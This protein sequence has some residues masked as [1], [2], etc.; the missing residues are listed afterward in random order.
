MADF[1][2]KTNNI[3]ADEKEIITYFENLLT[4]KLFDKIYPLVLDKQSGGFLCNLAY[5]WSFVDP[6]DKMIV[7]QARHT[8]TPAKA[9][10]FFPDDPKFLEAFQHGYKF[11]KEVMWDKEFG[12]FYTMRNPQGGISDYRGYFEEKRTYG[13]AFGIYA[14]AAVYELTK[15]EEVLDFAI[16]AFNWIEAHA[17]DSESGGYFQFLTREGKPFGKF[18]IENTKAS[19]AVEAHYKDQNSSIHLL[20]AY[21]EL[22]K[23]FPNE[24]VKSR[25]LELLL[26]IRDKITTE[27]GYMNLFFD[28]QWNPLSFRNSTEE[29]RIKNYGLD[30]VSF[31]HD[32]ETAFLML[33]ASHALGLENDGRTL[34]VARKMVDHA[35]DNGF[36]K[37]LGGFYD[38]GYYFKDSKTCTIINDKKN[39]WSQ[40]EG[41]NSLLLMSKIFPQE[42]KYYSHF[43]KLLKYV[44]NY[45]IDHEYGGWYEGGLDKE[46]EKK[47]GPKGHIWKACYHEG[48]SLMNCIKLLNGKNYHL[49]ATNE[50]FRKIKDETD[51][52]IKHWKQVQ[53]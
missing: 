30:H 16:E 39:W 6:Q 21:T 38:G 23:I 46:P 12:G 15:K 26:L 53:L 43:L 31:G 7:T 9:A 5:D 51:L 35:I 49:Y 52:F 14:L 28:R 42:E 20:E 1:A 2:P 10:Q 44:D 25:L 19:D 48:R 47:L 22:Y 11:L 40:A 29:E 36:D 24:K 3:F 13:N 41:L 37:V 4:E 8:W 45:F 32:Y 18:E 33:E 34:S 17:Y 50:K 27:K